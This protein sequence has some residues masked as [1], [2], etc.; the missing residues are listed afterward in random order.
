MTARKLRIGVMC[1]GSSL[2]R[3]QALCIDKML[4]TGLVELALVVFDDPA[5]YPRRSFSAKVKGVSP[6]KALFT[7][8]SKTLYRPKSLAPVDLAS[9]FLGVPSISC[10]V[11]KKG[12]HSQYFAESDLEAIR[13]H[14]LD[15]ILRFGF[16]IIRGGV[17]KSAR[18]GVW[19]F[20]HDDE[21]RYRGGPPCFWEIYNRDPETGSVLQRLTDRL[22]GGIILKKGIFRTKNFSYPR[23]VDQAYF[24]SAKWPAWVCRDIA[25]GSAD[26]LHDE[27]TSTTA[28]IYR[29]PTNLQFIRAALLIFQS[30]L[31]QLLFRIFVMQR[32]NVAL[33]RLPIQ[34]LPT[35]PPS[36]LA[37]AVVAV[38]PHRNRHSFNADS[39]GA[40]TAEGTALL[41]EELD[42]SASGNGRL[43]AA[44]L[45]PEG[46]ERER[47]P[48]EGL[49]LSCHAS[50]PFLFREG[51][52]TYMIPE[53][54]GA[55][56]ITLFRAKN[57]PREWSRQADLL[58]GSP[59]SD[60][61]L[62]KHDGRYWMFYTIHNRDYDGD[63]HLHAAF[64]DNLA[65]PFTPHPRNPVKISARSS[66][67]AGTPFIDENGSLIRPAQNFCRT[68]GGSV[69]FNR[70]VTLTPTDF[71]EE[72]VAELQPFHSYYKD[73]LHTVAAVD[74]ETTLV[75]MKRHV[76]SAPRWHR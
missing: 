40:P 34:R 47:F 65:L 4:A 53:T 62:V 21:M 54:G 31:K 36:E 38:L 24:E 60:A 11:E 10:I 28:Q 19:S 12:K 66:R 68:Y 71:M 74:A 64:S 18:Y 72:E 70:V 3:W 35:A 58:T 5:N 22:D 57:F 8:Y 48:L 2:P 6:S 39:F 41:F 13:S 49:S 76:L 37:K 15:I 25:A 69:V 44:V 20:H 50:Y 9:L 30:F 23:N 29:Y 27:P 7:L 26:Y 52:E 73:G 61:T 17:L 16:N 51:G 56:R 43:S 45:D 75:D 42:Y 55:E 33:V 14:H 59:F 63:L 67:P 32:W 1:Q 46:R